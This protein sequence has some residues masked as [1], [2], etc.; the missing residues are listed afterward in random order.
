MMIHPGFE[1][2]VGVAV[3]KI[4]LGAVLASPL[5]WSVSLAAAA[6]ATCVLYAEKGTPGILVPRHSDFDSLA[7][8]FG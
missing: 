5:F 3:G 2:L 8:S 7:E 6:V 1:F 4:V